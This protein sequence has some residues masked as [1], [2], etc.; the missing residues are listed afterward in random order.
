VGF[1]LCLET[2]TRIKRL[3]NMNVLTT[4]TDPQP[5]V[6]VPRSTTFDELIFTDDSTNVPIEITID[7]VED[8]SYYQILNVLCELIENRFYNV[9]L[10]NEGDLI[11]RGKVFCT[12]QPI[13]SFS[14]NNGKYVSNSTTNQFIVYE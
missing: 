7:S 5:L 6:I 3:L 2:R 14:V 1:F 12:D 9:E 4:T 10:F 8:K 11:F 13:V